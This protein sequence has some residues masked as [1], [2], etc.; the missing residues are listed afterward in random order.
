[1]VVK[2]FGHGRELLH[3]LALILPGKGKGVNTSNRA[4]TK[5][6]VVSNEVVSLQPTQHLLAMLLS[7]A[8]NSLTTHAIINAHLQTQ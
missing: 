3:C 5:L 1:M 8:D 4:D 6:S 2:A 7:G